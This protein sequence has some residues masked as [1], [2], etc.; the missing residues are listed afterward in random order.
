MD[1]NTPNENEI[2]QQFN[3]QFGNSGQGNMPIP[4]STG[5][6]VLGILSIVTCWLYGIPGLILGIIA[7]VLAGGAKKTYEQNP[8][9]Y[10]LASFN[11]L[12]AGRVCAI[13]GLSLSALYLLVVII[14]LVFVGATIG[15]FGG[16]H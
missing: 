7:M 11:N 13:I 8:S 10:S 2:N 12:K 1:T 16:F 3:Q 6:L 14:A 9:Q 15:T 5:V 4:N